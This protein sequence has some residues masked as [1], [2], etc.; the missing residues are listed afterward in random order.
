[1]LVALLTGL[2]LIN[3]AGVFGKLVEAHVA[4]ATTARASVSER[5][6]VVDARLRRN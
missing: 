2:A 3:A 5:M 1:V 4:M 6:E